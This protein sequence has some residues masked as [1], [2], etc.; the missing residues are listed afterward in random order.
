MN[1]I[2]VRDVMTR[3]AETVEPHTSLQLAAA[4]MKAIHVGF[5]TVY[6][7]RAGVLGVI[8]DRDIVVR[9]IAEGAVPETTPVHHVMSANLVW[10]YEEAPLADAV[11]LMQV[12]AVR[13]VVVLDADHRL[14]GV[15]SVDDVARTEGVPGPTAEVLRRTTQPI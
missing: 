2:L 9:A 4:R 12:S 14:A 1:A 3:G 15:L 6:D 13:R 7:D 10:C 5:L 8:T 11:K